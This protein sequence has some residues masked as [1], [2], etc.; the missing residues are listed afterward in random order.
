MSEQGGDRANSG[1]ASRWPW[2]RKTKEL[3][4][5]ECLLAESGFGRLFGEDRRLLPTLARCLACSRCH[6]L[7]VSVKY[8]DC[9]WYERC[10]TNALNGSLGTDHYTLTVERGDGVQR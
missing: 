10:D 8:K 1:V 2:K 4:Q 7:S 3:W 9:S 6:Y 5:L